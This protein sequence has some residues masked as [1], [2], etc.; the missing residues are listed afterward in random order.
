MPDTHIKRIPHD[1]LV[2]QLA[3]LIRYAFYP[4]PPVDT[5]D[6]E[7]NL[8]LYDSC[9]VLGMF[10]GERAVGSAYSIEMTQSVRGKVLPM[11]GVA[12][13][14]S[15]PTYRRRGHVTQLLT[16]LFSLMNNAG[17]VVSTLYPFR[18]SFYERKGY[19][20]FVQRKRLKAKI[21]NLHPLITQTFPGTVT[22]EQHPSTWEKQ[23]VFMREIQADIHGFGLFAPAAMNQLFGKKEWWSALAYD[24]AGD[25]I[26]IMPYRIS[27]F[28]ETF[29]VPY[30]YTKNALGRYLLLQFAARHIDQV[31]TLLTKWRPS[32]SNGCARMN[33]LK[34]G[35]VI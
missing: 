20:T 9:T 12:G 6:F 13:V 23:H 27:G 26:G 3:P 16:E 1:Q 34:H 5:T 32:T 31:E 8:V 24:E 25:L 10:D 15:M 4:S 28:K 11:G 21:S 19:V 2:D 33:A 29:Q 35:L 7:D 22:V 30:L 14:T 18:E 17:M